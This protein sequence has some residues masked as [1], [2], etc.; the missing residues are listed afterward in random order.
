MKLDLGCLERSAVTRAHA[1]AGAADAGAWAVPVDKFDLPSVQDVRGT[2]SC[3]IAIRQPERAALIQP[4]P[5]PGGPAC[6]APGP[7]TKTG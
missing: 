6:H 2:R 4:G 1:E 7:L 3:T 5:G